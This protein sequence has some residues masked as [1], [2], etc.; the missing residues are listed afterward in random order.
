MKIQNAWQ[1]KNLPKHT[2]VK[3]EDGVLK[4]FHDTPF[5]F[6]TD[7]DFTVYNGHDPNQCTGDV[8]PDY[9]YKF[10]DLQKV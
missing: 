1:I 4:K 7:S 6:L 2:I 10:Y 3:T 9:M 5:R 8:L